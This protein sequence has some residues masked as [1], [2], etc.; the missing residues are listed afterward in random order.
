MQIQ[1]QPRS[2]GGHVQIMGDPQEKTGVL[3][4]M[5]DVVNDH[6]LK[7]GRQEEIRSG[8]VMIS[9]NTFY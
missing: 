6:M 3:A 1:K 5:P 8:L 4:G 9:V 2:V 7:A